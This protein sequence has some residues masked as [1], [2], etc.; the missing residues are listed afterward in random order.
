MYE[1]PGWAEISD[2]LRSAHSIAVVGLSEDPGRPSFG[3]AR[4]LR[5]FGLRIIP[6]N[7]GLTSPVLGEKP[8]PSLIEVPGQVDIVDIFRRPEFTPEIARQ[9]VE[10]GAGTLWMQLG[11]VN[12]EAAK[13]AA[14]GGLTVVMDRCLAVDY[15]S[16]TL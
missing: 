6:V 4:E 10:I 8:Y 1:H 16:L 2:I 13:I 15:R 11:V 9:A 5:G 12:E 7:P 14:D 3:V